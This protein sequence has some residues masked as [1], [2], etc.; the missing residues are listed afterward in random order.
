MHSLSGGHD[1]FIARVLR[2]V[3]RN[4]LCEADRFVPSRYYLTNP[5]KSIRA[6]NANARSWREDTAALARE[7]KW[8]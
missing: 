1:A 6:A 2:V 3:E 4:R 8:N 5:M 7:A